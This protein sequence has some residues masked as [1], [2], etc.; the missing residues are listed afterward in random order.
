MQV[1]FLVRILHLDPALVLVLEQ[2]SYP[3]IKLQDRADQG[4]PVVGES[5]DLLEI[6]IRRARIQ[7][8]RHNF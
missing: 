5:N 3:L 7:E 1:V 2:F 6:V 4:Q 8:L